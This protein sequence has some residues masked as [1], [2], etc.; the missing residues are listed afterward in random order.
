MTRKAKTKRK[1]KKLYIIGEIDH[2]LYAEFTKGMDEAEAEGVDVE[3]ELSSHGGDP[4]A[5]FAFY[6]RIVD[7]SYRTAVTCRGNANSA[8][9]IILACADQRR[10]SEQAW[11]MVHDETLPE[12][13]PNA[14]ALQSELNHHESVEIQ[15]AELLSKHSNKPYEL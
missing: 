7:Y 3:I 4:Y 6:S 10:M 12:D 9:S 8:A 15:W 1:S 13:Q 11:M 5:A 2:T 14:K